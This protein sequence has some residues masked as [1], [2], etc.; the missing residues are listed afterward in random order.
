MNWFLSL[1]EKYYRRK[2]Y[3]KNNGILIMWAVYRPELPTPNVFFKLHPDLKHDD[4]LKPKFGEIA[5][6]IRKYYGDWGG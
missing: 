6:H 2:S 1:L 5:E 3:R 4:Y